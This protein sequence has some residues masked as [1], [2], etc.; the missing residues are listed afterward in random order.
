TMWR[1]ANFKVVDLG[2]NVPADRYIASVRE[3]S[4]QLV[5]VSALLTTTMGAMRDTVKALR[6]ANIDGI[7]IV[8]GG[9]PITQQFAEEIGADAYAADAGTA[10][11]VAKQLFGE[12]A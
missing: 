4:A 2:T 3:H 10:I 11:D 1:G 12:A 9:A 5:G 6:E 7:R 8:V